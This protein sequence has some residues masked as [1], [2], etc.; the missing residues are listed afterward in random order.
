MPLCDT[1]P[2]VL[3]GGFASTGKVVKSD[4]ASTPNILVEAGS[5]FA[6]SR[7]TVVAVV[8]AAAPPV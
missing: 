4:S 2:E 7:D 1:I 3:L 8:V 6:A 5:A